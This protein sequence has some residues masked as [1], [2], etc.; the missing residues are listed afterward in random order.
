MSATIRKIVAA[1]DLSMY[2]H[3]AALR[4]GRLAREHD[5]SLQLLHVVNA[6][7]ANALQKLLPTA[8]PIGAA[9]IAEATQAVQ[10]LAEDVAKAGGPTAECR[11]EEGDVTDTLL[12]VAADADLVVLGPRG[13]NPAKDFL[14][15]S[16][17]ERIARR[18][19]SPLLIAKQEAA[20]SYEC[21]LVPVDFS[22]SS[23]Q[24]VR[25]ARALAPRATLHVFHAYDSP[26]EGRLRSAGVTEEAIKSYRHTLQLEAEAALCELLA[27]A[28]DVKDVR[29]RVELGDPRVAICT[30]AD[31]LQSNLIVMGK[32]GRSWF[33]EF[34]LGSVSRRTIER[35]VCDVAIVPG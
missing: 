35:A 3:R 13:L 9:M 21:V 10:S 7:S 28:P 27:R 12:A 17:A 18:V 33:S 29:S 20:L 2:A 25:F 8:P 14:L 15:G 30:R 31:E 24:A 5:A 4:A 19:R 16:S 1:T 11:I 22:A 34:L 23:L 32:Q 26:Y 6:A